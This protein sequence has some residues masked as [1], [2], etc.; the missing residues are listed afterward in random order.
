MYQRREPLLVDAANKNLPNTDFRGAKEGRPKKGPNASS[1]KKIILE[2][3]TKV[4]SK[5]KYSSWIT[6]TAVVYLGM[7]KKSVVTVY[8]GGVTW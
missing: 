2:D 5:I 7:H 6:K 1:Y 3:S 8:V 4:N